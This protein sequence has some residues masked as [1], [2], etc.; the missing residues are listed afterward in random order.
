ML[1]LGLAGVP[2]MPL[3]RRV[4]NAT[5][6]GASFGGDLFSYEGPLGST[7]RGGS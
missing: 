7:Q 5:M 2:E 6:G 1:T 4:F 3:P